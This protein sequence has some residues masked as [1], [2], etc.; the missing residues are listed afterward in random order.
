M[1]G[2]PRFMDYLDII[3]TLQVVVITREDKL[4]SKSQKELKKAYTEIV[5]NTAKE[6]A[7]RVMVSDRRSARFHHDL[8]E[9][10]GEALRLLVRLKHMIA[11]KTI[12][13]DVISAN[14]QR[15][16]DLLE[17]QLHEA[18]DIITDLR[19]EVTW[20]RDRLEKAKAFQSQE[21]NFV[22]IE[23]EETVSVHQEVVLESL[24]PDQEDRSSL[25]DDVECENE[26]KHLDGLSVVDT[27]QAYE[28]Q[29]QNVVNMEEEMVSVEKVVPE[30][31]LESVNPDQDDHSSLHDD[32]CGDLKKAKAS[33]SQERN[34]VNM[35]EEMVSADKVHPEV[36]LES[37]VPDREDRSSFHDVECENEEK[38]FDGLSVVDT[39]QAYKSQEQNVVNMEEEMVSVHNVDQEVVIENVNLNQEDHSSLHD[40]EC[41]NDEDLEKAKASESQERNL[42]NMEEEMVSAQNVDLEVVLE[43]VNPG[44][45][46]SSSLHDVECENL[47][48]AKASES[49]ERNIVNHEEETVSAQKVV[50][51]SLKPYDQEVADTCFSLKTHVVE[52]ENDE[53]H[54]DEL[55]VVDTVMGNDVCESELDGDIRIKKLELSRNGCTQRIHALERIVL[56]RKSSSSADEEEQEVTTE[57]NSEE[58]LSSGKAGTLGNT[59]CLVLALRAS[60]AEV[61]TLPS[62]VLGIKK[63]SKSRARRRKRRFGKPKAKSVRTQSHQLIKPCCQSQSNATCSKTSTSDGE[64]SMETH[65]SV[66][67][68]EVLVSCEGGEDSVVPSTKTASNLVNLNSDSKVTAVVSDQISE[69]PPRA[70]VNRFL[71]YT[72]QRKR[73]RGSANIHEDSNN[74]PRK[75]QENKAQD[76]TESTL[77]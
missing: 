27:L 45:E 60:S 36:V 43:S 50:L 17:A 66:E 49:Q 33:E 39:L 20:V 71:K 69:S 56:E 55:S 41:Q 47:E 46:D 37:L 12:E 65:L 22:N 19:S 9:T 77:K 34:L 70:N 6:S 64:D 14:K 29:E 24:V 51:E 61:V 68:K 10:K 28:L 67:S 59:R 16:I 35:D 75:H 53:K 74:L 8:S 13:A 21:R 38:Q 72:F 5:L 48:K 30:V 73:K 15:Q 1:T 42:V 52:C 63:A 18:E 54:I 4:F 7:A 57:K 2:R 25:H 31:V 62:N 23:E 58:S 44:E 40:V 11:A 26:E 76:Q 3:Y 32:E